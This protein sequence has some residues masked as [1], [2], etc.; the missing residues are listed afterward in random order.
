MKRAVLTS[1]QTDP[2]MADEPQVFTNVPEP[3]GCSVPSAVSA[4]NVTIK[5]SITAIERST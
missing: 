3:I 1:E 4:M 2:A 5:V